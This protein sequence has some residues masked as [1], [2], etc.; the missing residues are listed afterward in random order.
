MTMTKEQVAPRSQ[1]WRDKA[2]CVRE[3]MP[4]YLFFPDMDEGGYQ[5]TAANTLAFCK[6]CPVRRECLEHAARWEDSWRYGVWG[7]TLYTTR[8]R[9]LS[10]G[11]VLSGDYDLDEVPDPP[12]YQV[13]EAC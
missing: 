11:Q 12:T 9:Y 4:N 13:E 8:R 1:A 3:R 10:R 7:G 6:K 5:H 2:R